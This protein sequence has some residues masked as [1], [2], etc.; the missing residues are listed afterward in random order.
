MVQFYWSGERE[1]SKVL[2]TQRE[3]LSLIPSVR[4]WWHML[5]ISALKK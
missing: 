2:A 1:I 5:V 4:V 3:D